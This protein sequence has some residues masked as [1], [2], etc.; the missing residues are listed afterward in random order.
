VLSLWFTIRLVAEPEFLLWTEITKSMKMIATTRL[1]KAQQAMG[2][3]KAY[4]A[5]NGEIFKEA[6]ADKVDTAGKKTLYVAISS[7]RGLCGGIHSSISKATRKLI[8]EESSGEEVAPL[9]VLGDKPKAQ[10]SRA[11]SKNIVLSFNQIGRAVPSFADALAIADKIEES[12]IE[13]EKV[14]ARLLSP[15]FLFLVL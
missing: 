12:G 13:F 8:Q 14:G 3:A 15:F 4:G 10:L 7:D 5:A 11:S 1:A 9:V 6:E 2:Q